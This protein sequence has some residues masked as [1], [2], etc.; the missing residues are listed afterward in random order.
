MAE[1]SIKTPEDT[2]R[3]LYEQAESQTAKAL[4]ELVSKPSFGVMFA[5]VAEN[6]AAMARI[7]TS[8][9]DMLVR[10]LRIAGRAD[11]TKLARQLHRTEDKLERVLQEVEELRDELTD[12]RVRAP[13]SARNGSRSAE[14]AAG[15]VPAGADDRPASR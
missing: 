9:A 12:E 3:E 14:P 13:G 7:S 5:Q 8:V 15:D 10:N 6:V 2:A 4:E 11:I 1:R